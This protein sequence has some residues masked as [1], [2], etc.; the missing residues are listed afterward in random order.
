ML[1]PDTFAW[2]A[3]ATPERAEIGDIVKLRPNPSHTIPVKLPSG[4]EIKLVYI[5]RV[6]E[7]FE[8]MLG[9]VGITLLEPER[10]NMALFHRSQV[11]EVMRRQ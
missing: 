7:V 10:N 2:N 3:V 8:D 1:M 6:V 5:L 9:G 11:F 4:K